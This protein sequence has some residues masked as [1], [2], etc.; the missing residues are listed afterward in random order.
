MNRM[1]PEMLEK[2]D[3]THPVPDTR[4]QPEENSQQ[5]YTRAVEPVGSVLPVKG[6]GTPDATVFSPELNSFLMSADRDNLIAAI[7]A[8]G[9]L[10]DRK[11][12]EPLFRACMDEDDR[13]KQAAREALAAIAR[14][15]R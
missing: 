3:L 10:G 15:S 4:M 11:A 6:S 9:K 7:T 1:G 14:K 12:V 8:L 13:V 5:Y 2:P